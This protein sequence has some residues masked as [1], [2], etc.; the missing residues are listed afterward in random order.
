[1]FGDPIPRPPPKSNKDGK[2]KHSTILPFVWTYLFKDGTT[3]KAQ[4]TCND[5]KRYGLAITMAH[6]YA[7]CVEQSASRMFW[8]LAALNEM[9][10]IGADAGNAFA[11]ADPPDDSLFMSIDDQ[12]Q[13][14]WIE[15]L[16]KPPIPKGYVLPVQHAI[17]R[18]PESPQ[19]WE[20]HINNILPEIGFKNTTHERCIYQTKVR[21]NKFFPSAMLMILQ[22]LVKTQQ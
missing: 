18:H 12:Y 8:S 6:T 7:S 9:A 2:F 11:E 16:K 14:W 17:Q 4:G 20:K 15:H 3:P 21:N 10:V 19:L 1:M 22:W 5:G 13:R